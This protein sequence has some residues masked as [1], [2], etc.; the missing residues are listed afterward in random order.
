MASSNAGNVYIIHDDTEE[1]QQ[2]HYSIYNVRPWTSPLVRQRSL[3]DSRSDA[4][5]DPDLHRPGDFK[6]K[7]VCC[8]AV[9]K[10][11]TVKPTHGYRSSRDECYYGLPTNLL[12]SFMEI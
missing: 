2:G 5:H 1:T 9:L 6:K 3:K 12:V 10:L 7:Q 4:D 8:P 11:D